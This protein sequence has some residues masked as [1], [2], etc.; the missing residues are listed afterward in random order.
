MYKY[1]YFLFFFVILAISTLA[2]SIEKIE[3]NNLAPLTPTISPNPT[4]TCAIYAPLTKIGIVNV[5]EGLNLREFPTEHS[6]VIMTLL[7][8]TEVEILSTE[9]NGWL[10]VKVTEIQE[11]MS[12][13]ET[14][15]YVNGN[16]ILEK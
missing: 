6:R 11:D 10:C 15:G 1:R 13:I 4:A 9:E 5:S 12:E 14:I 3:T 16:Y 8:E 7:P 2:C